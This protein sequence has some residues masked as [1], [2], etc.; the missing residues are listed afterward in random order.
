MVPLM[1]A[2]ASHLGGNH[3]CMVV[4]DC[5]HHVEYGDDGPHF[6]DGSREDLSC[7]TISSMWSTYT[8]CSEG[9][10]I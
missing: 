1:D 9:L 8:S 5:L 6:E 2:Q 4:N 3:H 7:Y 10:R